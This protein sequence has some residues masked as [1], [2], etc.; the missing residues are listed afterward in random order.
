[1][2]T[3][4]VGS[5]CDQF[6]IDSRVLNTDQYIS[7]RLPLIIKHSDGYINR[8]AICFPIIV[9][10]LQGY[11][12]KKSMIVNLLKK[13][14]LSEYDF[15]YMLYEDMEYYNI[16]AL[17]KQVFTYLTKYYPIIIEKHTLTASVSEIESLMSE[18]SFIDQDIAENQKQINKLESMKYMSPNKLGRIKY[19]LSK[20]YDNLNDYVMNKH[21][22]ISAISSLENILCYVGVNV[23]GLTE[24]FKRRCDNDPT[25]IKRFH[26]FIQ[27][28]KSY[29]SLL[30][31]IFQLLT[32]IG[33]SINLAKNNDK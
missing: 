7:S 5:G 2:L 1:M 29:N 6:T 10:F 20:C 8:N 12:L 32:T 19:K 16:V 3:I 25:I 22:L 13:S 30:N 18:I 23:I 11:K 17:K 15:Y 28:F 14:M 31:F 26:D 24:T 27:W 21:I 4:F 9:N 33:I